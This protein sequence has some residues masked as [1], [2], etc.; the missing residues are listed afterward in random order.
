MH[1]ETEWYKWRFLYYKTIKHDSIE[2]KK[3]KMDFTSNLIIPHE[4]VWL[5]S[6][7]EWVNIVSI[8]EL[9]TPRTWVIMKINNTCKWYK[10][11][12]KVILCN[13]RLLLTFIIDS[14]SRLISTI[15]TGVCWTWVCWTW[16]CWTW[17]CWTRVCWTWVCKHILVLLV[18]CQVGPI[19]HQLLLNML[20]LSAFL[21]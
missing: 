1:Y 16:V 9:L 17:V 11:E 18:H 20:I 5:F 14:N 8:P 6:Q 15:W 10:N 2:I 19:T 12:H 7:Q 21:Y 13:M 3:L 4:K